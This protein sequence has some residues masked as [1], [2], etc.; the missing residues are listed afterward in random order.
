MHREKSEYDDL[1]GVPRT[2]PRQGSHRWTAS[3]RNGGC[4]AER[5]AGRMVSPTP[6]AWAKARRSNDI[7]TESPLEDGLH[8]RE[9]GFQGQRQLGKNL[10]HAGISLCRDHSTDGK[11]RQFGAFWGKAG[12]SKVRKSAWWRTQS[13]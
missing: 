11:A 1:A 8:F 2:R 4:A 7:R 10:L 12:N 5:Y 6:N 9:T 13:I 3:T